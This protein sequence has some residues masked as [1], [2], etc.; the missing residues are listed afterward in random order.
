MATPTVR[1]LYELLMQVPRGQEGVRMVYDGSEL[2]L[3]HPARHDD[4]LAKMKVDGV[5]AATW[6][7]TAFSPS[8]DTV[9]AWLRMQADQSQRVGISPYWF[10]GDHRVVFTGCGQQLAFPVISLP[11][12]PKG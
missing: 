9:K 7:L 2:A 12:A 3:T 10:K 5:K 6:E 8:L 11:S 4:V 1:E